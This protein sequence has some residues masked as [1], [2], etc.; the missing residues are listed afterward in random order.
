MSN[1]QDKKKEKKE[2]KGP[3]MLSPKESM[4]VLTKMKNAS[5]RKKLKAAEE[6]GTKKLME[7]L[8][9]EKIRK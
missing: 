5:F 4:K 6:K 1:S 7:F 3:I 2:K 9:K 8:V